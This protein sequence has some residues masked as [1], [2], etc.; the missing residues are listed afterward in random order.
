MGGNIRWKFKEKLHPDVIIKSR[1]YHVMVQFVPL[2]FRMDK[3]MDLRETEE[4]NGMDAGVITHA[5][6]IKPA[7][8]R[9][10][11]QTCRHLILTLQMATVANEV[12]VHGSH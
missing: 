11:M 3:E 6:W 10:P 9:A 4:V 12:L 8:R 7:A 1:G 5:R 2:N